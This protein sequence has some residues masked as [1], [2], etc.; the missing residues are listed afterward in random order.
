MQIDKGGLKVFYSK[1]LHDSFK[2]KPRP[3]TVNPE[4]NPSVL[5]HE[6]GV[7]TVI[8]IKLPQ[9][10]LNHHHAQDAKLH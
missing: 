10:T 3:A 9:S 2:L 4:L 5:V 7:E 6:N 1:R 8:D